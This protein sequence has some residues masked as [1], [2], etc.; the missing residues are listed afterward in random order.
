MTVG[1]SV[2]EGSVVS[3][4][5]CSVVCSFGSHGRVVIDPGPAA[6]VC[7][8][9]LSDFVGAVVSSLDADS[10]CDSVI[11]A[12]SGESVCCCPCETVWTVGSAV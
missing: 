3:A 9:L 6:G 2:Y 12:N 7:A 8:S 11:S 1:C 5:V 4:V 10:D